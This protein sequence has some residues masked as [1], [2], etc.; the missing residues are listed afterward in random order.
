MTPSIIIACS[1]LA[2]A[3]ATTIARS[4][5]QTPSI[6]WAPSAHTLECAIY[7]L[8]AFMAALRAWVIFEGRP[9]IGFSEAAVYVVLAA[10]ASI[11][12]GKVL[13]YACRDRRVRRVGQLQIHLM[14]SNRWGRA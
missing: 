1:A 14:R 9:A 4:L 2:I 10:T 8:L 7:D 5:L 3:F 11:G 6:R 13:F 12:L